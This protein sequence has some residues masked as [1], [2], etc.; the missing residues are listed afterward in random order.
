MHYKGYL[1]TKELPTNERIE[2]ILKKYN[3]EEENNNS[4]FEWDWF[5]I[6]GRYGGKIKIKFDP[7]ENEDNWYMFKDRNNKYFISQML[8]EIKAMKEAYYDELDYLIYMGLRENKLY[9]DGAY[10]K[11]MIDFDIIDC[12]LVIEEDEYINVREK[13]VGDNWIE[14]KKFDDEVK[15]LDLKDKFITIID[16]HD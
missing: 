1:I 8:N 11:D 7:N 13:W 3:D 10:Y 2:E 6:G 16:F 5:I 14:N 4:G 9:V 15:Q 12:Y